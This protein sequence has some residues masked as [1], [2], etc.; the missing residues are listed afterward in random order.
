MEEQKRI[1]KSDI[2][3]F[4]KEEVERIKREMKNPRLRGISPGII[5]APTSSFKL[6]LIRPYYIMKVKEWL[7]RED[8]KTK[9][10]EDELILEVGEDIKYLIQK[11]VAN[12]RREKNGKSNM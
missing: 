6:G 12:V 2:L 7:I 3:R 10:K 4:V 9:L 5:W 1:T 8:K 11:E